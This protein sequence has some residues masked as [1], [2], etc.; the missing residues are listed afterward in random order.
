MFT[1][2][3]NGPDGWPFPKTTWFFNDEA[4][5]NNKGGLSA[6]PNQYGDLVF[7]WAQPSDSGKYTCGVTNDEASRSNGNPYY[8]VQVASAPDTSVENAKTS[9]W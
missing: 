2:K 6:A 4:I 9:E 7:P 3:C 5:S 8:D 1:L